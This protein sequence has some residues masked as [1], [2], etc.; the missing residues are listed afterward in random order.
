MSSEPLKS[1]MILTMQTAALRLI[2]ACAVVSL[3]LGSACGTQQ[4]SEE[5]ETIRVGVVIPLS[6]PAA[7]LG[8]S[9]ANGLQL[10][11]QEINA[12]GGILG[13]E[14]ELVLRDDVLDYSMAINNV[15]ALI[16]DDAVSAILGPL[17]PASVEATSRLAQEAHVVQIVWTGAPGLIDATQRPYLFSLGPLDVDQAALLAHYAAQHYQRVA[18]LSDDTLYGVEGS[19]LLVSALTDRGCQVTVTPTFSYGG[20]SLITQTMAIASSNAEAA[21][22]WGVGEEPG[23]FTQLIRSQAWEGAILGS[24]GLGV[25]DYRTAAQS[26]VEGVIFAYPWPRGWAFDP[27]GQPYPADQ[28]H[29]TSFDAQAWIAWQERY[30]EMFG[31]EYFWWGSNPRAKGHVPTADDAVVS[32]IPQFFSYTALFLLKAAMERAGTA[33]DGERIRQ[34]LEQVSV[35]LAWSHPFRFSPEN[36]HAMNA[37]DQSLLIYQDD[38]VTVVP[39][40]DY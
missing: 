18:V 31:Q 26:D 39:L 3:V 11:A 1:R 20:T 7:S 37:H 16:R 23:E 9:V 13:R 34:A 15:A 33:T 40:S 24:Q 4:K 17:D 10:A 21:I 35:S 6:G 2:V 27:Q 14:V 36:H 30:W 28:K 12:T 38:F 8:T 29:P 25:L 5:G 32:N 19:Q 22:V